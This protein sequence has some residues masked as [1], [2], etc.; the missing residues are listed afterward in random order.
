MNAQWAALF[1]TKKTSHKT[2]TLGNPLE[3]HKEIYFVCITCLKN[4]KPFMQSKMSRN[5]VST[6]TR[7]NQRHHTDG[8]KSWVV[9]SD[10]TEHSAQPFIKKFEALPDK[11]QSKITVG[12]NIS[13]TSG[14]GNCSKSSNRDAGLNQASDEGSDFES[15]V[16]SRPDSP[17]EQKIKEDEPPSK[18]QKI[19]PTN[20]GTGTLHLIEPR[21]KQQSCISFQKE[22][23][24]TMPNTESNMKNV[25]SML[26]KILISVDA[27][28]KTDSVPVN[29][30]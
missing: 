23:N 7:H 27:N 3:E 9:Q 6:I 28:R 29:V 21:P 18:M 25:M 14:L 15:E 20:S 19:D 24:T 13:T 17:G 22:P 1:E 2:K 26:E 16:N 10:S 12:K 8:S 30:Q 11:L 5:N 4:H